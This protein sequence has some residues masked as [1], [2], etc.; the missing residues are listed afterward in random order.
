MVLTGLGLVMGIRAFGIFLR[1]FFLSQTWTPDHSLI[2]LNKKKTPKK[3]KTW[4]PSVVKLVMGGGWCC[5]T[6]VPLSPPF[7]SQ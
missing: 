1:L 6:A 7:D 5:V 4:P 2:T 3:P